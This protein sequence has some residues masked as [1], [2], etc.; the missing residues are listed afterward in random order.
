MAVTL[1]SQSGAARVCLGG[2]GQTARGP[3]GAP[4]ERLRGPFETLMAEAAGALG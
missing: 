2:N 1:L 3:A 4:E